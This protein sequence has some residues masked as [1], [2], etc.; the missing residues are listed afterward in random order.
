MNDGV[1]NRAQ[2]AFLRLLADAG[3]GGQAKVDALVALTQRTVFVSTWGTGTEGYRTL[4]NSDGQSALPVF[5]DGKRADEAATRFGWRGADGLASLKEIGAREA[6]RYAMA[7]ELAYVVI[8]VGDPH[9]LEMDRG[10]IEPLLTPEARRDGAGPYAGVGRVSSSMMKAVKSTPHAGMAQVRDPA[11]PSV[12]A[13]TPQAPGSLTA[14]FGSGSS[15]TI[16]ALETA[17]PEPLLEGLSEVLRA[18]PEVEWAALCLAARGP[19]A[20]VPTVGLR[21]DAGFRERVNEIITAV[22]RSGETLG[23]SLDVLLLDNPQVMRSTRAQGI[24]FYPFRQRK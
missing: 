6:L 16:K 3:A 14:T 23:A 8:D 13:A 11:A 21:L 5:T 1:T 2:E 10:E 24:L 17:P 12:I 19:A 7:H 22:R 4:T 9:A 20:A 15:V 18:Y